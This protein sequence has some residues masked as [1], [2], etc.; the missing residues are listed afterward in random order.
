[1]Q[2]D[3]LTALQAD[4][5]SFL[6]EIESQRIPVRVMIDTKRRRKKERGREEG[7]VVMRLA[8]EWY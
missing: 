6:K 3:D 7:M 4:Q 2:R 1:L 8:V 5:N